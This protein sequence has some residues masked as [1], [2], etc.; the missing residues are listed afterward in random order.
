MRQQR[1]LAGHPVRVLEGYSAVPSYEAMLAP[2]F[3]SKTGTDSYDDE[4]EDFMLD[5]ESSSGRQRNSSLTQA[6]R[7]LLS[8]SRT[9][10]PSLD[11]HKRLLVVAPWFSSCPEAH[12]IRQFWLGKVCKSQL[13]SKVLLINNIMQPL[14]NQFTPR[15]TCSDSVCGSKAAL[16]VNTQ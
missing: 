8:V 4:E 13:F 11:C 7:E 14:H 16:C 15:Y 3:A 12:V 1:A 9:S 2:S 6:L 10:L 5:E